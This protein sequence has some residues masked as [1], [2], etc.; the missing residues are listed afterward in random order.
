MELSAIHHVKME[1]QESVPFA[2]DT[3]QMACL[4]VVHSA[5]PQVTNVTNMSQMSRRICFQS[6]EERQV[7][8]TIL[9]QLLK[10]RLVPSTTSHSPSATAI[11][12]QITSVVEITQSEM[13]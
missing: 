7:T 2:G 3:A 5:W 9:T 10:M 1:Q 4:N 12:E 6:Q 11:I 13:V 8:I